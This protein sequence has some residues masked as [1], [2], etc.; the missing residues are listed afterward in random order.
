[1]RNRLTDLSNWC[2]WAARL[3][4][5]GMVVLV[6][7]N[8]ILRLLGRPW[9]GTYDTV[10]FMGAIIVGLALPLTTLDDGHIAVEVFH[11]K[12][13]PRL[14]RAVDVLTRALSLGFFIIVCWQTYAYGTK[15]RLAGEITM[16]QRWPFYPFVY[17]VS[18]G[19]LIMCFVLAVKLLE[20]FY[21][22]EAE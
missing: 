9:L 21:K 1:M 12:F 14:R 10:S 2:D 20:T 11:R 16:T 18:F 22:L 15:M 7:L 19:C 4:V 17:I 8:I 3:T 5:L 6:C 13:P